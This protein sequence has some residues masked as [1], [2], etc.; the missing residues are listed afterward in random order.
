MEIN[1]IVGLYRILR[2]LHCRIKRIIIVGSLL[3]L[4]V[5]PQYS[6][7]FLIRTPGM[8]HEKEM[9]T[10]TLVCILSMRQST[11]MCNSGSSTEWNCRQYT[12]DTY[13]KQQEIYKTVQKTMFCSWEKVKYWPT[14][15]WFSFYPVLTIIVL[16]CM[17]WRSISGNIQ[18][19]F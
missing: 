18:P 14:A 2:C 19:N 15:M 5:L 12:H 10:L 7:K 17:L 8:K 9:P 6:T 4:C 3:P 1:H 13:R 16:T 11:V